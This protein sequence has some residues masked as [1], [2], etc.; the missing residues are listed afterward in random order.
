MVAS[1]RKVNTSCRG[2]GGK[3][4]SK[5]GQRVIASCNTHRH[6][7]LRTGCRG[8]KKSL[9]ALRGGGRDRN[10]GDVRQGRS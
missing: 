4:V 5:A 3:E 7:R 1:S 9:N 8:G 6:E 2:R 10:S